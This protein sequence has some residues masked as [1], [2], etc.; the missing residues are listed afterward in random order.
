MPRFTALLLAIAVLFGAA[1]VRGRIVS[2]TVR[3]LSPVRDWTFHG[4]C[5]QGSVAF[6]VTGGPKAFKFGL[7]R[8]EYIETKP[9]IEGASLV[10]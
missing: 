2:D 4:F 10:P 6:A 3:V 8:Y 5:G 1:S 9:P 7:K